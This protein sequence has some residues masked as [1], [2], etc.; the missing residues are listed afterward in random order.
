MR[1][2]QVHGKGQIINIL[3][4]HTVHEAIHVFN[5]NIPNML[6]QI[7]FH[8]A[9]EMSFQKI[10]HDSEYETSVECLCQGLFAM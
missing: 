10:E 8:F 3:L 1:E 6:N 5:Q 9:S 7:W 2:V 4:Q